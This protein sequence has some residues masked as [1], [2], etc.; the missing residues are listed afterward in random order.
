MWYNGI[1]IISRINNWKKM[2]K[3]LWFFF[4]KQKDYSCLN[5]VDKLVFWFVVTPNN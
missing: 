2:F 5:E 1:I 3:K 4:L